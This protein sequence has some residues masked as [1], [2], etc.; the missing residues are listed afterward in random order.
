MS[1]GD[2][3]LGVQDQIPSQ[4]DS[5]QDTHHNPSQG[6]SDHLCSRASQVRPY[7]LSEEERHAESSVLGLLKKRISL[8]KWSAE[9]TGAEKTLAFP[10]GSSVSHSF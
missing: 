1:Q 3:V 10:K 5:E 8:W 6:T 2:S 7:P 4:G 9:S